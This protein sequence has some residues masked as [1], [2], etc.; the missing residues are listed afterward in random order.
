[1]PPHVKRISVSAPFCS[2][3]SPPDASCSSPN[4]THRWRETERKRKS[5]GGVIL[6]IRDYQVEFYDLKQ[7]F[8][9]NPVLCVP[10]RFDRNSWHVS[11][12]S[13]SDSGL[14]LS[15]VPCWND[16]IVNSDAHAS[17]W[18]FLS[19][20]WALGEGFVFAQ[21]SG[22]LAN[23]KTGFTCILWLECWLERSRQTGIVKKNRK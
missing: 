1:M 16:P 8:N 14:A 20:V 7:C 4:D 17:C 12:F 18:S 3:R 23:S 5:K 13:F 15:S 22:V 11:S 2:A 19:F 10:W 6:W 21:S 9:P